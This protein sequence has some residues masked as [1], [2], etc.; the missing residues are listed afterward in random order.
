MADRT[1]DLSMPGMDGFEATRVIRQL[2]RETSPM[3]SP[4]ATS[5]QH[6]VII[7]LT[8][9]ADTQSQDEAYK[10]GVDDFL[11]KPVKFGMITGLLEKWQQ[12]ILNVKVQEKENDTE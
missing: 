2:E 4:E 10:A 1:E 8:G 5:S 11:I 7:A 3:S 6:M 12:K 9:L